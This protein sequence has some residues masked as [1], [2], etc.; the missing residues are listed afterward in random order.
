MKGTVRKIQPLHPEK[1]P[2]PGAEHIGY[3]RNGQPLFREVTKRVRSRVKRDE[4]GKEVYRVNPQSGELLYKVRTPV[5]YDRE[6]VFYLESE[7]TNNVRRV[8]YRPPSKDELERARRKEQMDTM[9][10]QLLEAMV[11]RGVSPEKFVAAMVNQ[12][13]GLT[14]QDVADRLG[15]DVDDLSEEDFEATA[16]TNE[17]T[18]DD[19]RTSDPVDPGREAAAGADETIPEPPVEAPSLDEDRDEPDFS[20]FPTMYGPGRWEFSDGSKD[21]PLKKEEAQRIEAAIQGFKEWEPDED[22]G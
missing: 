15:K 4:N 13:D 11:D 17:G 16:G 18:V 14:A 20:N 6:H 1:K 21:S 10:P 9:L 2:P 5:F 3:T 12:A 8:T 7:G 19:Q 22:E